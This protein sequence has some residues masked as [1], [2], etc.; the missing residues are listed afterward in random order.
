MDWGPLDVVDIFVVVLEGA[1]WLP[2][3]ALR[4]GEGEGREGEGRGGEGRGGEGRGG[5]GR[6]GEG[7]GGEG[8]GGESGKET[9]MKGGKE[10]EI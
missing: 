2:C 4:G 3:L 10:E 6:G 5:E 9:A 7:R 8:R 1:Q